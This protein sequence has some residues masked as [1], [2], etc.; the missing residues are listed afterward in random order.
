[1][2]RKLISVIMVVLMLSVTAVQV[3]ANDTLN[4]GA[5]TAEETELTLADEIMPCDTNYAYERVSIYNSG[6]ASNR[7]S[8][9]LNSNYPYGK[10]W[11]KNTG[12][13]SITVSFMYSSPTNT[14]Y[15]TFTLAAG[16]QKIYWISANG[17]TGMHYCCLATV[18]GSSLQGLITIRRGTTREEMGYES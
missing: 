17:Q 12:S 15:S 11:V 4:E 18:D 8:F 6:S 13:S 7:F 9:T 2:Y 16:S 3:F 14:P 10:V 1:M 5:A